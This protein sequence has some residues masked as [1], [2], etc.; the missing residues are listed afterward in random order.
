MG[1]YFELQ[2]KGLL[3]AIYEKEEQIYYLVF[4]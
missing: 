3:L 2:Y 1:A 4:K